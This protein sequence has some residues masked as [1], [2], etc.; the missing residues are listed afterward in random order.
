MMST[1]GSPAEKSGKQT[2]RNVD[3]SEK[4]TFDMLSDIENIFK[5]K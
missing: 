3:G 5:K 4:K 1:V 2:I